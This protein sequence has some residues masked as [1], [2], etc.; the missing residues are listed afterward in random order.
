MTI[1]PDRE[2]LRHHP[3]GCQVCGATHDPISPAYSPSG[4]APVNGHYRELTDGR[5]AYASYCQAHGG[6]ERALAEIDQAR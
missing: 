5:C 2:T 1:Y 6:P 4:R 3:P